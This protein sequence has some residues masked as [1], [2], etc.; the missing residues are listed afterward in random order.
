MGEGK[1]RAVQGARAKAPNLLSPHALT[2]GRFKLQLHEAQISAPAP[3]PGPEIRRAQPG[4]SHTQGL[5]AAQARLQQLV[6]GARG[7]GQGD[8]DWHMDFQFHQTRQ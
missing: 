4:T 3:S 5:E 8:D 6:V 1:G 7:K 2:S